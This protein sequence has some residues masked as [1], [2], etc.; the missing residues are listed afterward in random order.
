MD[1]A[2]GLPTKEET[3]KLGDTRRIALFDVSD[4]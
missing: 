4:T 1:G 2:I 3:E